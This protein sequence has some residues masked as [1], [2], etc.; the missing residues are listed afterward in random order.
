MQD[1][2]NRWSMGP[3]YSMQ[4][5]HLLTHMFIHEYANTIDPQQP[6]SFSEQPMK[7]ARPM[8]DHSALH[9]CL[10]AVYLHAAVQQPC[11]VQRIS[12]LHA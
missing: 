4:N 9:C 6:L 12:R 1:G 2:E 3:I 8:Y 11:K 7:E 5:M 10:Q